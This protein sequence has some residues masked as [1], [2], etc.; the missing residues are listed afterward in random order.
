[1]KK[2]EKYTL[3]RKAEQKYLWLRFGNGLNEL[4]I[5][6]RLK[7]I[8]L[9]IY[10][11]T[12]AV[13]W[14]NKYKAIDILAYINPD[15]NFIMMI[16]QLINILL[17]SL[18]IIGLFYLIVW[19]G[20]PYGAMQIHENLWRVGFVNHAGE[21]PIL[22]RKYKQKS[23]KKHSIIVMEF[24]SNGLPLPE[25]EKQQAKIET[26]LNVNHVKVTQG[27]DK[28]KILL[29]TVSGNINL[30]E[31][32]YWKKEYLSDKSFE[33]VLGESLLGIETVNLAKIP[34]ILL[35]GSTGSG[36]S[37]LLKL[38]IMQCIKKNAKVYIADFKGGVDFASWQN[39]CQIITE[40][41]RLLEVLTDIVDELDNRKK[42]FYSTACADINHYN[43]LAGIPI[44]RI[45]FACDE[46]AEMLDKT[47]LS[48][49]AK[50][51][52][53]QIEGKLSVIARQGRAFGIHLILATQR[54]DA[55]ILTG[56]IRNNID[57]RVCGR[58][59]NVLSQI[60]LD[61]TGAADKIPKDAQGRFLTHEGTVFQ[62]Y[63]F[64]ENKAF[65]RG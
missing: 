43:E 58:A 57:F 36:K 6:N 34:H 5:H 15:D 2:E 17:P 49:E 42:I 53:T 64:D 59:D 27:S 60:I 65:E 56:Q 39:R 24:Q 22:I 54:P 52:I 63:L 29:Y 55:N 3:E 37:V 20:T 14:L 23:K 31:I 10:L 33:L 41:K 7:L 16:S 12:I 38:L 21:T 28:Q 47:G 44:E 35:G 30:P 13:L 40:E 32:I 48:K 25:W 46:V 11:T 62:G 1:M 4:F 8:I 51:I 61:N 50:E 19:V 9:A 18:S 26:A 45:I